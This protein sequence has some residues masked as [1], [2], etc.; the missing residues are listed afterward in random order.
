MLRVLF[1]SDFFKE[2]RFTK[3]KS[4][5]ELVVGVMRLV[6][7]FTSP[8]PNLHE[9]TYAAAYMG[10]DLLNPPTVEGWH[11]GKE[12]ID[13]GA[14]VERVNFASGQVGDPD[15]P[16]VKRIIERLMDLGSG[17]TAGQLLDS[18]LELMGPMK[19]A[20]KRHEDLLAHINQGGAVT[21]S[22]SPEKQVFADRVARLLELIVSS[23]EF[24]FA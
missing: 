17:L 18:C 3:V 10:Q 21:F 22:T 7:D 2:S 6:D 16:G 8:K 4:P 1:N 14:L 12:W 20:P 15:K 19:V 24:Q 5:A 23:R 9:I 13:S 11:T